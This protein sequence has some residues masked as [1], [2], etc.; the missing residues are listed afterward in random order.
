METIQRAIIIAAGQGN[1][2]H[3]VTLETPKPL[4]KINGVRMIDTS[5]QALK[6]NGIREIYIVAGYKKEKFYE[7][8]GSDPIVQI[9]ENPF[10]DKG[11]NVTS[12]YF[13]REFLE[14]SFIIEG[15][16]I[17]S[18]EKVF[19]P[20]IDRSGYCAKW[21]NIVPEWAL[22]VKDRQIAGCNISGGTNSYQLFGISM[23]TQKDGRTLKTLLENQIERIKD[24]NIYWDQ[25]PLFLNK[26]CFHLG[27]REI[28]DQALEEID[29]FE[30]LCQKDKSY[31]AYTV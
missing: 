16:L 6:H 3:P 22:E 5:I 17:I 26:N 20:E 8:Y 30:E 31:L 1:R 23:W 21:K 10:F 24:W 4:V 27:I 29:T 2:L 11:N 7:V 15:D 19:R 14:D 9:I 13:A 18:N 12:L 28:P 25:I